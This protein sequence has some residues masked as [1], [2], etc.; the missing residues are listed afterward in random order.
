MLPES[1][2]E[3][4]FKLAQLGPTAEAGWAAK[5]KAAWIAHC[6]SKF[7]RIVCPQGHA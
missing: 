2:I 3:K 1:F 5:H 7:L 6:K 4:I